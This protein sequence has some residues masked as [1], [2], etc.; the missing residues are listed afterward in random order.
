MASLAKVLAAILSGTSDTNVRFAEL[1]R[2]LSGL[3][4]TERIKGRTPHLHSDGSREAK[5]LSAVERVAW[6]WVETA[7]ELGRPI[8]EPRGRLIYA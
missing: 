5:A 3:G 4:F 7:K 8:P 2:V 6:E 1:R